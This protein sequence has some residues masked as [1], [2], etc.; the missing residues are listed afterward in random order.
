LIIFVR[1]EHVKKRIIEYLSVVKI[2]GDLKAPI[3]CLAGP[4][5]CFLFFF[6]FKRIKL[7]KIARRR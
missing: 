2:K 4:V 6:F 5:S 3:I 7:L 1:L